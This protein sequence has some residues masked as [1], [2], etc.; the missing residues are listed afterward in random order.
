MYEEACE[1]LEAG[2]HVLLSNCRSGTC[3]Y[4]K[5]LKRSDESLQ[6]D[7]DIHDTDGRA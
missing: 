3:V 2:N 4:V 6:N 7:P 1:Q 5:E